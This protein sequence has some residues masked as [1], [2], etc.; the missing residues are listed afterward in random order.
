M[1]YREIKRVVYYELVDELE[2]LLS[3]VDDIHDDPKERA[4]WKR[5]YTDVRDEMSR[6]VTGERKPA[7]AHVNP[8]QL[9]LLETP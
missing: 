7:T 4:R 8:N 1:N 2:A 5:A 6:R 9:S 3:A